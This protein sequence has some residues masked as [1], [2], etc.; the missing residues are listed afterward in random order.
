MLKEPREQRLSLHGLYEL[1]QTNESEAKTH[2]ITSIDEW[3]WIGCSPWVMIPQMAFDMS[4]RNLACKDSASIA[5]FG[6]SFV[7]CAL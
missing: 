6:G 1:L 2:K 4:W 7:G 3:I 5:I